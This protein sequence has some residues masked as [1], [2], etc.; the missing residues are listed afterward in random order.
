MHSGII[1]I[2]RFWLLYFE[3][4]MVQEAEDYA[5]EDKLLKE[6]VDARNALESQLYSVKNTLSD[7]DK[8][9]DKVDEADVDVA[10]EF[11]KETLDWLDD[12]QEAE[13]EE[14]EAK[15]EEVKK[16]TE[17]LMLKIQGGASSSSSD[18]DDE[19]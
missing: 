12:N 13:K 9:E 16:E 3:S 8:W 11:I 6:K 18:D 5:E 15:L 14:Y 7:N 10:N 4:H 2:D 1:D 17:S 19:L